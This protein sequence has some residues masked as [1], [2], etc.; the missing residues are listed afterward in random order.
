MSA[1]VRCLLRQG[2]TQHPMNHGGDIQNPAPPFKRGRPKS[3]N[4]LMPELKTKKPLTTSGLIRPRG[5]EP[6]TFGSGDQRS[7]RTELRA[8]NLFDS[9]PENF[10][11]QAANGQQ[12]PSQEP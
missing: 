1:D 9:L 11:T 8:L 10:D 7:I 2:M 3:G 5:F 6:L 12:P 4:P